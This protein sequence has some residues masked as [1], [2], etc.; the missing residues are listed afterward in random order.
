MPNLPPF[1]ARGMAE[2][3]RRLTIQFDCVSPCQ[4]IQAYFE[5]V[6]SARSHGFRPGRGCHTALRA[7]GNT[8]TGATWFIEADIADCFGSLD[9]RRMLEILREDIHDE[10]FLRLVGGMLTPDTWST[11]TMVPPCPGFP[12]AEQ[13]HRSCPTFTCTSW[14]CSSNRF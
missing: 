14:T 7:I 8:W 6:F 9:H 1:H 11:G 12:R 4:I 2:E 5:P 3:G 10:W 13:H